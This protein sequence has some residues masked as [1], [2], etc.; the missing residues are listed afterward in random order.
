MFGVH[1]LLLTLVKLLQELFFLLLS[2][3]SEMST[4]D[5]S[6]SLMSSS[7]L[8]SKFKLF[9]EKF[10]DTSRLNG[11]ARIE[12]WLCVE[13]DTSL[14]RLDRLFESKRLEE[15]VKSADLRL[16]EFS[17]EYGLSEESSLIVLTPFWLLL[18]FG[19]IFSVLPKLKLPVRTFTIPPRSVIILFAVENFE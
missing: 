6:Y 18:L 16:A 17:S 3:K 7:S 12:L 10:D 13:P 11:L 15:K 19:S 2:N 14:D 8:L 4:L 9:M 1:K 5:P